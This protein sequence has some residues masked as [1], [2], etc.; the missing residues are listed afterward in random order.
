M[1]FSADGITYSFGNF[2]PELIEKFDSDRADTSLIPSILVGVTLGSGE[3]TFSTLPF[4]CEDVKIIQCV[5]D[6]SAF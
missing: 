1:I 5:S 2:L 4:S 3:Y 6:D